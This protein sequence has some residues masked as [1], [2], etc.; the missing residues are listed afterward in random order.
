LIP[1]AV[2]GTE[3]DERVGRGSGTVECG[4]NFAYA[5]VEFFHHISVYA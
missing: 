3:D 1:R 5:R 2:V 4:E